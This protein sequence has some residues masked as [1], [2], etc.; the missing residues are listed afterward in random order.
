MVGAAADGVVHLRLDQPRRGPDRR[1]GRSPSGWGCRLLRRPATRRTAWW[2]C[3]RSRIAALLIKASSLALVAGVAFALVVVAAAL[4]RR[5]RS[6][7]RPPAGLAARRARRCWAARRWSAAVGRLGN[8]GCASSRR[9]LLG[10]ASLP[11]AG[12]LPQPALPDAAARPGRVRRLRHLDPHRLGGLR[13]AGGPVP[14]ARLRGAV[15]GVASGSWRGGLWRVWRGRFPVDRTVFAFLAHR[16]PGHGAVAALGRVPPVRDRQRVV[17]PGPLPAAAAPAR[18][19]ADRGGAHQPAGAL[20]GRRRRRGARGHCSCCSCSRWGWWQCG[21]MSER[22]ARGWPLLAGDRCWPWPRRRWRWSRGGRQPPAT[23]PSASAC[24]SPAWPRPSRQ[25]RDRPASATVRVREPL[26]RR[27]ADA[28][29]AG[30][31]RARRSRWR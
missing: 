15:R 29:R 1:C 31:R 24:P 10:F 11:V 3:W 4:A 23:W 22:L 16:R 20:A 25:R 5:G 18:G 6:L 17:H 26:P 19:R 14:G 30:S 13:V 7:R 27:R 12:L 2:R 9:R 21:S 8:V 28:A